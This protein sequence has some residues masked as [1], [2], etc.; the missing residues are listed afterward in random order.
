MKTA[1]I[2][3]NS[4]SNKNKNL[5]KVQE[6]I[7]EAVL[8]KAKFILLPEVFN[9][10]GKIKNKKDVFESTKGK[11][12]KF[13]SDI[14]KKYNIFLLAGSIY[15]K[16]INNKNKG[17]NTSIII[18][19][20]GNIISKYRKIN[21]FAAKVDN[22]IIKESDVF[23]P[24]QTLEKTKIDK[25]KIGLTI[26]YDLRFPELYRR[27]LKKG[28]NV[29]CVPSAFTQ[30]TG[31]AHWHTLL[32]ARAIENLSYVLA[33]NQVGKNS[34]NISLY[35]HSLVIDPWGEI[36]AEASGNKEEII[37]AKLREELIKEKRS[38][39]ISCVL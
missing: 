22:K 31:K 28:V 32:K 11:T 23:L 10:Q 26:C 15:E 3:I 25:F 36:I 12:I 16:S 4:T 13:C 18:S 8:K 6:F 9:F 24:G 30:T 7:K 29:F 35:G 19:P 34:K 38:K 17:Y 20:K 2:Q 37:Y 5:N 39:F 1:L 21:L 27:Y 14:C 33:P